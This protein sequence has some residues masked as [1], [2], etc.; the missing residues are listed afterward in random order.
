MSACGLCRK[1]TYLFLFS[2]ILSLIASFFLEG[3]VVVDGVETVGV[4]LPFDGWSAAPA[5]P[6]FR[7]GGVPCTTEHSRRG[8]FDS[9]GSLPR[10]L[11]S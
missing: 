1:L 4:E 7:A 10:C 2:S 8:G 5:I 6:L 9:F 11:H 3:T